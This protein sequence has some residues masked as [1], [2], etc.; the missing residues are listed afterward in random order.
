M[1]LQMLN[2]DGF[3]A[4]AAIREKAVDSGGHIPI[5]ALT[6]NALKGDEER[7]LASGM[8]DYVSKPIRTSELLG[9]ID[10][11]MANKFKQEVD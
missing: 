8:G 10:R 6:A 2:M 4:T 9:P 11:L 3:E 7:C 5:L 1:D